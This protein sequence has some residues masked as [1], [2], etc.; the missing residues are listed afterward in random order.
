MCWVHP[1]KSG[2]SYTKISETSS[3]RHKDQ[4]HVL[5]VMDGMITAYIH[6]SQRISPSPLLWTSKDEYIQGNPT[7]KGCEHTLQTNRVSAVP[8]CPTERGL[9][10]HV[11]LHVF[12]T[13]LHP[14]MNIS[15]T[16]PLT[17]KLH[18]SFQADQATFWGLHRS[19][20]SKVVGKMCLVKILNRSPHVYA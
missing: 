15:S 19:N 13:G 18:L 16:P 17:C 5:I 14:S 12:L 7:M 4:W 3:P 2:S 6:I 1:T 20:Y 9:Y 8:V 10:K 11:G